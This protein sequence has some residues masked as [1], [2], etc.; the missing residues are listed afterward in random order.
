MSPRRAA[1]LTGLAVLVI[2]GIITAIVASLA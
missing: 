2:G 1:I